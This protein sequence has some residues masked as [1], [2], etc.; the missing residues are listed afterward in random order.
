M[1]K[2]ALPVI[3]IKKHGGKQVAIVKG[4]IVASG[5]DTVTVLKEAKKYMPHATWRDILLVSVPK[6]LTVVYYL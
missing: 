1:K 6:G 4:K 5:Y 2:L 3:S